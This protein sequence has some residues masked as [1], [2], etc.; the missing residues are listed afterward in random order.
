MSGNTAIAGIPSN[1]RVLDVNDNP[2]SSLSVV[3]YTYIQRI[4][5]VC[6]ESDVSWTITPELPSN[7]RLT[8]STGLINGQIEILLPATQFNITASNASGSTSIMFTIES[9]N[10]PHGEFLYPKTT[11]SD[12][13]MFKLLKGTEEVYSAYISQTGNINVICLPTDTYTY[14]F[15]CQAAYSKAC[16]LVVTGESGLV[17]KSL[18]VTKDATTTGDFEMSPSAAPTPSPASNPVFVTSGTQSSIFISASTIR[19]NFTFTPELPATVTFNP[20]RS[21]IEGKWETQ[22]LHVFTVSCSNSQGEGSVALQVGVDYC[23]A[24]LRL[25]QV[26]RTQGQS[27]EFLNITNANGET[28][29]DV[30]FNGD[31]LKTNLCLPEGLYHLHLYG[32]SDKGWYENAPLYL[33]DDQHEVIGLY[34]LPAGQSE[35]H[36][37]VFLQET[38]P[39]GT[40]LLFIKKSPGKK[41]TEKSFNT[42]L[43]EEGKAG[44][45]GAFPD[46]NTVYFRKE[47]TVFQESLSLHMGVVMVKLMAEGKVTLFVDGEVVFEEEIPQAVWKEISLPASMFADEATLAVQ[48]TKLASSS[49][50]TITFDMAVQPLV[51]N[52]LLRS[53]EGTASEIQT[54][55]TP[56][57]PASKAFSMDPNSYWL[58]SSFPASLDFAFAK[59]RAAV[60]TEIRFYKQSMP[61]MPTKL[62]V[63]GKLTSSSSSQYYYMTCANHSRDGQRN[64]EEGLVKLATL[65]SSTFF[66]GT[67]TNSFL[68]PATRAFSAY[69]IV[70]ESSAQGKPVQISDVRLFTHNRLTCP[71]KF[72]LEAALTGEVLYK[73]CSWNQAGVRRMRCEDEE[74]VAL[75]R[76]DRSACRS[77]VPSKG[78]AYVDTSFLLVNVT[79][80]KWETSVKS[81]LES[82]ITSDMMVRKNETEYTYVRDRTDATT[83]QLEFNVRFTLEEEIGDYIKRHMGYFVNDLNEKMVK[84]YSMTCP[85]IHIESL[86]GPSLYEPIPWANFWKNTI[87][88]T[89][90]VVLV[91][92]LYLRSGTHSSSKKR[93]TRTQKGNAVEKSGL[94]EEEH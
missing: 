40:S 71:K 86:K 33:Y 9:T 21:S 45:W 11:I 47:V 51:G 70:F 83:L 61:D 74:N 26:V 56:D 4:S 7:L 44:S 3:R 50:T 93:L 35:R 63:Y 23:T 91:M 57:H 37:R 65:E 76:D 30:A 78:L 81:G 62:T 6:S 54:K 25:L 10:C 82:M 55:P 59:N 24:P 16:I 32:D 52:H 53:H 60:I 34:S 1:I 29:L 79:S 49:S 69:R 43:W 48:L 64:G 18:Q 8:K 15:T 68:L 2:I 87:L 19:G 72:G 14:S 66:K 39:A 38:V 88:I 12:Q 80:D 41:W 73:G 17:Y 77:R 84:R 22:G 5:L 20:A 46:S 27:N 85:G 36:L 28:L 42:R 90:I 58:A 13:G 89:I 94:L 31:S 92:V 67:G 75:W